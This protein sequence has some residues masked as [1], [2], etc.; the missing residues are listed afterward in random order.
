MMLNKIVEVN[1]NKISY[2]LK[3]KKQYGK[4]VSVVFLSG[5]RSDKNGTKALFIESLRKK[6]GFE[7]LRFDYSGHGNSTGEIDNLLIS[8]WI[9]ESKVLIERLT[10]Y[11]LLL[12]GSSMG[13]WI[14]FYLSLILK[15]KILAIIGIAAA[16]DFTLR[17]EKEMNKTKENLIVKSEYSDAPYI[18]TKKF[19][20]D[21]KKYFFA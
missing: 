20:D 11:P 2:I 10:N 15:K 19:I 9:N 3:D 16:A 6:I 14:S 7:Y 4:K 13:G 17:M 1:N 5:Y 8:D 18:F 21:S 12:I